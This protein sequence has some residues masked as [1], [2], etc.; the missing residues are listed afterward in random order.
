MDCKVEQFLKSEKQSNTDLDLKCV[1]LTEKDNI[2]GILVFPLDEYFR[3][4]VSIFF[5]LG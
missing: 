4:L 2:I 3:L 5:Y 1:A